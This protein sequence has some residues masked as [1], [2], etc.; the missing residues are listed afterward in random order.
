MNVCAAVLVSAPHVDAIWVNYIS[1]RYKDS[2]HKFITESGSSNVAIIVVR[3]TNV[4][5]VDVTLV[6]NELVVAE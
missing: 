6:A 3:P 4:G 2:T 1:N 5:A